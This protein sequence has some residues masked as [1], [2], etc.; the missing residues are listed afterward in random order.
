M[1][2]RQGRRGGQQPARWR[3]RIPKCLPTTA[4]LKEAVPPPAR[5]GESN[6]DPHWLLC[7]Q[8]GPAGG[9][10]R[11]SNAR[12]RPAR[13]SCETSICPAGCGWRGRGR[14]SRSAPACPRPPRGTSRTAARSCQLAFRSFPTRVRSQQWARDH[15]SFLRIC[16]NLALSARK[17]AYA[18]GCPGLPWR[19]SSVSVLTESI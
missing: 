5:L 18:R 15:K 7:Q 14:P 3:C 2:R 6:P 4:A 8:G 19:N 9:S 12:G 16:Q 1:Q 11:P 10:K 13:P 17:L